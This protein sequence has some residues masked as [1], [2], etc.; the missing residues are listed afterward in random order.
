MK[1]KRLLSLILSLLF[2]VSAFAGCGNTT[3]PTDTPTKM[4]YMGNDVSKPVE[5]TMYLPVDA[6][7]DQEVMEAELNKYLK[8]KINAT[9]KITRLGWGD[10]YQNKL[11]AMTG[12]RQTFDICFTAAWL[13]TFKEQAAKGAF[14]KLNDLLPKYAPNAKKALGDDFLNAASINSTIYAVPTLKEKAHAWGFIFNKKLVDKY[15]ID[16]NKIN[17]LEDLEP[18]LKLIKDSEPGIYPLEA[19]VGENPAKLLDFDNIAGDKTPGVLY[20]D[21]KDLKPFLQF[22]S[23]EYQ[24]YF[25]TMRKYFE[26]DYVRK[27]APSV[28]DFEADEKAGKIFCAVKSL[29]PGKDVELSAQQ[30]VEWVQKYIT[31]PVMSNREANGAM[32]AI[33]STSTNQERALML[34]DLLYSDEKVVNSILYGIKDKHYVEKGKTADGFM[35]IDK[36]P[37]QSRYNPGNGWLFGNQFLNYLTASEDPKKWQLFEEFNKQATPTKSLGFTFD[38]KPVKNETGAIINIWDKYV[39]SLETGAADYKELLPKFKEELN[40]AGLQKVFDEMNKQ[41]QD[42]AKKNGK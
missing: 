15:K 40:Q 41:L 42:W 2:I 24:K 17:S 19:L 38:D 29:K 1:I 36:G 6:P 37:D 12:S 7:Q 22:E 8:G 4:E 10:N 27:D 33:S 32:L 31:K 18:V 30:G 25:E 23:P 13:F 3:A 20:N 26:A 11:I 34:I 5:L 35:V 21:S 14:I 39:P 9:V 16:I 28:T